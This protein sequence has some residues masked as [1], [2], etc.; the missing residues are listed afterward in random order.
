MGQHKYREPSLRIKL[1]GFVGGAFLVA[2]CIYAII[3]HPLNIVTAR[4]VAKLLAIGLIFVIAP[5]WTFFRKKK[6]QH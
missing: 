3:H 1:L 2:A 4:I 6:Q 5:I